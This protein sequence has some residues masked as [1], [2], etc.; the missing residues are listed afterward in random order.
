MCAT[1]GRTPEIA[2][3]KKAPNKV[4]TTR[5][6]LNKVR[7]LATVVHRVRSRVRGCR[8]GRAGKGAWWGASGDDLV[9][10][11]LGADFV[12]PLGEKPSEAP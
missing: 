8:Q 7:K 5:F 2:R 9:P 3:G 11:P 1:R 10:H 6:H 12:G 4:H